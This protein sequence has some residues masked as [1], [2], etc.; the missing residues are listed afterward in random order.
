VLNLSGN[1]T[2]E[3]WVMQHTTDGQMPVIRKGNTTTNPAYYIYGYEYQIF[4]PSN[5]YGGYYY[6][7]DTS[8]SVTANTGFA[9]NKW[10]H[11][12]LVKSGSSLNIFINGVP[13]STTT[14]SYN[15][16]EQ[17]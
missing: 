13:D 5:A 3:A 10:Y 14:T 1:W 17:H 11:V 4:F 2:L 6:I 15:P 8:E 9:I 7:A 16:Y 12:A